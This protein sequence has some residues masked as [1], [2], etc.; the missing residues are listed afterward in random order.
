MI[1]NEEA[2]DIL[3]NIVIEKFMNQHKIIITSVTHCFVF[4]EFEEV[5]KECK[6][7]NKIIVFFRFPVITLSKYAFY[8]KRTMYTVWLT[9]VES[10]LNPIQVIWTIHDVPVKAT[11]PSNHMLLGSLDYF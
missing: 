8:E 6:S 11:L 10:V 2:M 3:N 7:T 9:W 1:M 4:V 5:T